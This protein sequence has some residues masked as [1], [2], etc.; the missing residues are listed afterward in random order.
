M[1]EAFPD[2]SVEG[3]EEIEPDMRNDPKD[4]HVVAAAVAAEA[5]VIVTSNVRDFSNLPDAWLP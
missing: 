5:T 3:W 1:E 4:R 2:A